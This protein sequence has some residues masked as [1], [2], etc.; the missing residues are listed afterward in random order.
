MTF[1]QF[2]QI[3]NLIKNNEVFQTSTKQTEISIQLALTLYRLGVTGTTI[4]TI[5]ALFGIGDGSTIT[6]ITRRVFSALIDIENKYIYW[7]SQKERQHVIVPAISA[8]LPNC[9]GFVDGTKIE[10]DE[11]PGID[12]ESYFDKDSNYSL[13]LQL[14]CD[15]QLRIRHYILGYPGSVHDSRMWNESYMCSHLD[16]FFS[17]DEWLCGDKGYGLS[18]TVIT[19]FRD[20]T[21]EVS[22]KDRHWFNKYFSSQ[23]V[24]IEHV[25]GILKETFQSLKKLKLK[26]NNAEG[27]CHAIDWIKVCLILYNILNLSDNKKGNLRSIAS[28]GSNRD[29]IG[30]EM[31]DEPEDPD[32][33]DDFSASDKR[34][35]L[36]Y[37]VKQK[38]GK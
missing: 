38:L 11:A 3:Y 7:P 17:Q 34:M 6:R 35:A 28:A 5:A 31:D 2:D 30:D 14:I 21:T 20:N 37:F 26:I 23:R 1:A 19:P 22:V 15:H 27:H 8:Y 24:A 16:A 36:F 32:A 12:R 33:V 9:V 25:N 4:Q 10:L 13:Q 29:E 18:K